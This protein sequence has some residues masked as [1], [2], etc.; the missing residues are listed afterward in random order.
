MQRFVKGLTLAILPLVLAACDVVDPTVCTDE[1]VYGVQ[2]TVV[3]VATAAPVTEG[4]EG[5]LTEGAYVEEMQVQGV[6]GN[7]L[8]GAGERAGT[9]SLTIRANGYETINESGIVVTE[10]ECHVNPVS[11]QAELTVEAVAGR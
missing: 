4:L 3:D 6:N 1:F 5:T 11:L 7:I 10:N 2:V 9:Y 8:L